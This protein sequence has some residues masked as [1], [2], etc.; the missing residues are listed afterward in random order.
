[1][2]YIIKFRISKNNNIG[3]AIIKNNINKEGM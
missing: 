2:P 3:Y 1:M